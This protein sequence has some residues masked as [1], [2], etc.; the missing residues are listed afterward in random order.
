MMP[1]RREQP[2]HVVL[3]LEIEPTREV[4][5]RI[6]EHHRHGQQ[7][8]PP[9]AP[10]PCGRARTC[11][12]ARRR[13]LAHRLQRRDQR[14]G[15]ERG[16]R[17]A[18]SADPAALRVGHEQVQHQ[19]HAGRGAPGTSPA[20]RRPRPALNCATLKPFMRGPYGAI[21]EISSCSARCCVVARITSSSG[22]GHKPTRSTA[23]ASSAEHQEL[24]AVQILE[25]GDLVVARPRRRSPA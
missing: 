9:S 20:S 16:E 18:S 3:A 21:F 13:V 23:A 5:G 15:R 14:G 8:R 1:E 17:S 7:R 24:A 2:E 19:D 22:A 11:R 10:A 12:R 25:R 6:D 4:V